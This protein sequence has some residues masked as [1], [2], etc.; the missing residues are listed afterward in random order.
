MKRFALVGALLVSPAVALAQRDSAAAPA[1]AGPPIRKISTAS[2]VSTEQL[3]NVASVR[4]LAGG[5]VLVNDGTR[6]RLLLMD[7]S[8]KVVEVVLDSLTEVAN[9]YGTRQGMLMALRGDSTLFIDPASYAVLI[10]DPTAKIARVRSVPRVRDVGWLTSGGSNGWPA[11]DAKGRLV[12]RIG[13]EAGPPLVAPPK[14]V[15]WFPQDP[16]SAF[17]VAM[18]FDTRKLDTLG[19]IRTPKFP[20]QV[21]RS[22]EFGFNITS[23]T[24]PMPVT[25]DWAVVSDG[26]VAFVRSR[27][28]RIEYLNPDGTW[29][30]S[31]KLPF[32]WHR[33][34]DEDKQK[35]VD[36]V[37]AAQ[38]KQAMTSYVAGM[39]RWVN[40]YKQQYPDDF[41]VPDGFIPQQGYLKEWKMPPGL[42][43]PPTYIYGCPPGVEPTITAVASAPTTASVPAIPG[44]PGGPPGGPTGTPS[45]IPQPVMVAGGNAPTRPQLREQ[46][47]MQPDELPDYRPPFSGGAVRADAEGNLWIRTTPYKPVPGG[48][49]YDIVNRAGEMIDR[50]QLPQGY[51][52]V[53]FGK[54]R[55]V[56]VTMR[57][58]SG[59]HL[60]R[61]RLK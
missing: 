44:P 26:S 4:E 18:D 7:S 56:Y 29:K 20:L 6:R 57:D 2:A 12:Y 39:I 40:M 38:R 61:V 32:D 43:F 41:K 13:A 36:S 21:R 30:S 54:G 50:L 48:P 19:S 11:I 23:L 46:G 8:L 55:V 1:L 58:A 37:K 35:M 17:I 60:A 59:I 33:M 28:Y 49:V 9:S 14:G 10:L 5:R 42:V 24:N 27:D 15:P 34:T 16:D 47:V 22:G 25:D 45:C 52:V 31:A 51:N 53:G 3:G